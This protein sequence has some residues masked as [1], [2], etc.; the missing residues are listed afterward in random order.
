MDSVTEG[1]Q[2]ILVVEDQIDNLLI[3][4]DLLSRSYAVQTASGGDEALAL[5]ESGE[6]VDLIISDIRMPGMSGFE[7]CKRVKERPALIQVPLLFLTGF[8]DDEETR[9]GLALGAAGFIYKPFA[10]KEV[11][12]KVSEYLSHTSASHPGSGTAGAAG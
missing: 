10:L 1:R 7:F 3:L 11:M 4:E 6:G 5:L 2:R 12:V 9:Q 8:A